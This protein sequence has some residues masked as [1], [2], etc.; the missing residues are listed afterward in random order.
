VASQY[1]V[2][3][4]ER[5]NKVVLIAPAGTVRPLSF[6]WIRRAVLCALPQRRFT[7]NFLYWLLEDLA[8]EGDASRALLDR[9]I[10]A[11]YLAIR[12]Y[13]F[14]QLVNPSVLSDGQ[15]QGLSVP[16]L[17]LVGENEKIY[18]AH[19]AVERLNT[20]A[21]QVETEIIPDAGHDLTIVQAELVNERVL[22]FLRH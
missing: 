7:R 6:E 1:A 12:S 19:Q 3:V 21:P 15:L 14:K 11:A 17:F 9:E 10:D 20:V 16:T 18:P 4:P 5:L 2:T 8:R 22:E 13:K